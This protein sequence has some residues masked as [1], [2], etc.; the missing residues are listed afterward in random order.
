MRLDFDIAYL[1]LE[2]GID[3]RIPTY[4]G[5]LGVLAGDTMR[6]AADL[7]I[8]MVGV[9]LLYREGYFTQ[10]PSGG[11]QRDIPQPW[12]PERVLRPML[13]RVVVPID[14]RPVMLRAWR[15]DAVGVGGH[16][17]PVYF[18][19]AELPENDP[20]A[21]IITRRLYAGDHQHRIRQETVLGIGGPRML[22]AI[23]HDVRLFHMNEGHAS[24]AT[25]E[26]L[27]AC[28][29]RRAEHG[30][31]AHEALEPA[32]IARVRD[33]F[34]FTTHTPLP[35]GH[36]RFD[37]DTVRR[38]VGDHPALHRP[39]LHGEGELNTTRLAMNL[40]GFTNAVSRRHAEV[41]RA[42]F[43]GYRIESVTNGVHA[44][45]WTSPHMAALFDE[46]VPNWRRHNADL[47]LAQ[48][49]PSEAILAAHAKAKGEMLATVASATGRSLDPDALTIVFARRM[50]DYKR[51]TLALADPARLRAIADR[52]GPI[53]IVFA[54]KAHAH[55]GA[56]QEIV[57]RIHAVAKSL[58]G[59]VPVV[60]INGYDL[61]LAH[62]L[63]AGADVWL[64]VPRPPM[65][66]SGTSGMKAALNGVPGL[67]TLDGWWIEGC[68][69]GVTGWSIGSA[70]DDCRS[71]GSESM[72]PRH[73]SDLYDKLE[74]AVAPLFHGDRP[75]WA[76]VMLNCIAVN[77][78]YFTAERMVAEY[79]VR[80][81]AR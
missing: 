79:A 78:S 64:N 4:A 55:D 74:R 57:R 5:G 16:V 72:D 40:S 17:V 70:S 27:S 14:G 81:Y 60:F 53:Q 30:G 29:A 11:N 49:I 62:S 42:M 76:R 58:E 33:R 22:R 36:D 1:S 61:A 24:F 47:R 12:E 69:E 2:I 15:H 75:A 39:D 44:G 56:G 46:H 68:V 9:T 71:E 38:I 59:S 34:V 3:S 6:A 48:R 28:I 63:V 10:E 67:S 41:S 8:P 23:G 77:G 54:G 80:A 18:L 52:V 13:P 45:R 51:P 21:R 73:A 7:G 20:D 37:I 19:D 65:E 26:A 35:A 50:T 66:A 32:T 43:P 25:L 31:S